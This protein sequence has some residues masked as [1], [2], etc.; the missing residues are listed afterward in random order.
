MKCSIIYCLSGL[1]L[2]LVSSYGFMFIYAFASMVNP[3]LSDDE[4]ADLILKKLL[5]SPNVLGI[6]LLTII[7]SIGLFLVFKGVKKHID[8]R[9]KETDN[10]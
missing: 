9:N 1:A 4:Q 3:N 6:L 5:A 7:F 10:I 8:R 2:L